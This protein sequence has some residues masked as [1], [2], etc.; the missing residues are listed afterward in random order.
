MV[1]IL[2]YCVYVYIGDGLE[3]KDLLVTEWVTAV[4][5]LLH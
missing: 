5:G 1:V 4:A 3:V 2:V